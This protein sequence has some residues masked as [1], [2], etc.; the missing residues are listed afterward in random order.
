M[1]I[2]ELNWEKLKTAVHY[3]SAKATNPSVLGSIKLNKVLWYSDTIHYMVHG[4][5][6]TGEQYIKRQYGPVPRHILKVVDELVAEK[7]IARGKTDY[8]GFMKTEY[9]ALEDPN[10]E[11]LL[12]ADEIALIDQAFEH[13]CLNH[14]AKSVSEETHGMIWQAAEMGEVIPYSAV[15]VSDLGEVDEGDIAWAK[16]VL[17]AA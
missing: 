12:T 7:R 14:T 17:E 13:V 1:E 8:F 10:I 9:I 2:M 6:I 5:P 4:N 11:G 16:S 15:L 3:V